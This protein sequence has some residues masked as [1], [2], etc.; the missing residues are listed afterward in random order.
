MMRGLGGKPSNSFC[1]VVLP[2]KRVFV[3]NLTHE[4]S[5]VQFSSV[6]KLLEFYIL[7][8]RASTQP[9]TKLSKF[10]DLRRK[11]IVPCLDTP[12]VGRYHFRFRLQRGT[13][14]RVICLS[15]SRTN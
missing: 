5:P 13:S 9:E 10:K 4:S 14:P 8:G 7:R 15:P 1:F 12:Q 2:R 6:R 3:V 11:L